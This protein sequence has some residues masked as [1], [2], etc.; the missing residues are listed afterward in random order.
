MRQNESTIPNSGYF[1]GL[2]SEILFSPDSS[3]L[4]RGNKTIIVKKYI[5]PARVTKSVK[6]VE[7]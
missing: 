4:S 2:S 6:F 3:S 5:G 1:A 7:F